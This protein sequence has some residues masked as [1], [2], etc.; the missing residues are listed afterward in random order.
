MTLASSESD[1][2][3]V[4]GVTWLLGDTVVG[5]EMPLGSQKVN[6]GD[7]YR[8]FGVAK[9]LRSAVSALGLQLPGW[10]DPWQI[11]FDGSVSTISNEI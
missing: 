5:C 9:L 2:S 11:M 7:Y 1:T 10:Q 8:M 4:N 6:A 3:G